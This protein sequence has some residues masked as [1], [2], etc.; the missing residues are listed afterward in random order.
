MFAIGG[1]GPM[2]GINLANAPDTK[3]GHGEHFEGAFT[4]FSFLFMCVCVKGGGQN[5]AFQT[6]QDKR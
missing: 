1:N 2:Y 5:A 6:H 3:G 4:V